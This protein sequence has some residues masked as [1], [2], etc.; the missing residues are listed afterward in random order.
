[1]TI[2]LE[3]SVDEIPLNADQKNALKNLDKHSLA[4]SEGDID[5]LWKIA[6]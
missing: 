6:F 4:F 3:I 2:H 5:R 1:M